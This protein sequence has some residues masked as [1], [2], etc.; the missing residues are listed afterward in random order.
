MVLLFKF[1]GALVI[2]AY[3]VLKLLSS[4]CVSV[5]HFL[6]LLDVVVSS[7]ELFLKRVI[8][9]TIAIGSF[10]SYTFDVYYIGRRGTRVM[11]F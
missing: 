8:I 9:I 1:L 7:F 6:Y 11:L 10:A 4:A 3:S 5:K 2:Q